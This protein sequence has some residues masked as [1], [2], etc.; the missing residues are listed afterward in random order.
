MSALTPGQV[1]GGAG[2]WVQGPG[3]LRCSPNGSTL[4]VLNSRN[5]VKLAG[6]RTKSQHS[7]PEAW[8]REEQGSVSLHNGRAGSLKPVVNQELACSWQQCS[9]T[10]SSCLPH[11]STSWETGESAPEHPFTQL[12]TGSATFIKPLQELYI[13]P[14]RSFFVSLPQPTSRSETPVRRQLLL[15]FFAYFLLLASTSF[16]AGGIVH[17]GLGGEHRVLPGARGAGRRVFHGG[18]LPAGVRPAQEDPPHQPGGFPA[19]LVCSLRGHGH[20]DR[21][22]AALPG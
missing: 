16:I 22:R 9:G 2:G 12:R 1:I 14:L 8:P 13:P 21:R 11:S 6:D 20:D 4:A 18:Q 17:L 3:R 15:P 7:S 5:E 19:R 10:P